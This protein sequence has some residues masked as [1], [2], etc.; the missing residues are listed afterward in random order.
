MSLCQ[1][2]KYAFSMSDLCF[3]VLKGIKPNRKGSAPSHQCLKCVK[4]RVVLRLLQSFSLQPPLPSLPTRL[5][6]P[7]KTW[8]RGGKCFSLSDKS[9]DLSEAQ[10]WI[11]CQASGRPLL[12]AV[13]TE[14]EPCQAREATLH[15]GMRLQGKTCTLQ[16][17]HCFHT[18]LCGSD[19]SLQ[20]LRRPDRG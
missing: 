5:L 17:P 13:E 6:Q 16:A 14:S 19:E 15:S 3:K 2:G 9:L 4:V 11:C 18:H 1:D 7:I 12:P 8:Q 10:F 20:N